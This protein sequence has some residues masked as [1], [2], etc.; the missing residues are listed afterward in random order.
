MTTI[1]D[2]N[3]ADVDDDTESRPQFRHRHRRSGATVSPVIT[4]RAP[5]DSDPA[6]QLG[7]TQRGERAQVGRVGEAACAVLGARQGAHVVPGL[8]AHDKKFV[9][10]VVVHCSICI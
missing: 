8:A 3:P 1:P 4:P 6:V 10:G 2:D 7:D 9:S 5:P